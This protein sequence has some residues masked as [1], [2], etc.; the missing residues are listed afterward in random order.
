MLFADKVT[1][2]KL[3]VPNTMSDQFDIDDD[4][5]D[6]DDDDDDDDDLDDSDDDYDGY[7]DNVMSS[8]TRAPTTTKAT[9]TTPAPTT[10]T[11]PPP[12]PDPYFTHFDPHEEHKA[13]KEAQMRLEETHRE[14]VTKVSTLSK[15]VVATNAF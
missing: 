10:T 12:T 14:K 9:T 2:K 4:I 1:T 3:S 7:D 8:S 5:D 11:T 13:Y 15:R 6:E